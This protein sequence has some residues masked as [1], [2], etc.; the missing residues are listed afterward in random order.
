MDTSS[1]DSRNQRW[2]SDKETRLIG[3]Y[4]RHRLLWDSRHPHYRDRD[5]RERAM[6]NIAQG[7]QD[8]FDVV[9]VKNK[10]KWLRDYFV[11]ELKRELGVT[12]KKSSYQMPPSR[13]YVSRWEHFHKWDFLRGIFSANLC[14]SS[15]AN[16]SHSENQ[17]DSRD[18]RPPIPIG[19]S[20]EAEKPPSAQ[21]FSSDDSRPQTPSAT[22]KKDAAS[23]PAPVTVHVC[24]PCT[25][26]HSSN[27]STPSS[28]VNGTRRSEDREPAPTSQ[29]QGEI[30]VPA[31]RLPSSDDTKGRDSPAGSVDGTKHG[32]SNEPGVADVGD[33]PSVDP[34]CLFVIWQLRQ[35]SPYQRDLAMLRIRQELFEAKYTADPSVAAEGAAHSSALGGVAC[36]R[37]T[38]G[39]QATIAT[40][41]QQATVTHQSRTACTG[42]P[43]SPILTAYV[44][45]S[46]TTQTTAGT[47]ADSVCSRN[48]EASF[49]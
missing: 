23:D 1:T 39:Q 21:D 20:E 14:S 36:F 17:R 8:E 30:V 31:F 13:G 34:F 6:S 7:L 38:E 19:E 32:Q 29:K 47:K 4:E 40:E 49:S 41:G 46:S 26:S 22:P 48:I 43:Q 33:T 44:D 5:R 24:E 16:G 15:T 9:S 45:S 18:K 28:L 10:I 27:A 3:L 42:R 25:P 37:A 35:M 11:K 2:T 12:V